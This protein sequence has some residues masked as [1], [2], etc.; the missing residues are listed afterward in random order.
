MILKRNGTITKLMTE[1][2]PLTLAVKS[3]KRGGGS[4]YALSSTRPSALAR[5]YDF[6]TP[7]SVRDAV[8]TRGGKCS[9]VQEN[10]PRM[11]KPRDRSPK[12]NTTDKVHNCLLTRDINNG[13]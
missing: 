8:L 6:A 4:S 12:L 3:P 1:A 7:A 9:V 13:S 11:K 2:F 10:V 5:E